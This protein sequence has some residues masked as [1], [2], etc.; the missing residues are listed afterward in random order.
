[1]KGTR[2]L[3]HISYVVGVEEREARLLPTNND[4][5]VELSSRAEVMAG[6]E[7]PLESATRAYRAS[8]LSTFK[9]IRRIY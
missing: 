3:Y 8:F 2:R 1:M 4:T 6:C 9:H 7:A 5:A